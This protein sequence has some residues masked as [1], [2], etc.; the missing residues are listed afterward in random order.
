[1]MSIGYAGGLFL[2]LLVF[3]LLLII[4]TYI[5][6]LENMGC[7]CSNHPNKEFIKSYTIISIVFLLFTSFISMK[8]VYDNFGEI[9]AIM[10]S[11][12]TLVFYIIFVFYIYMSFEYVRYLINEKCK[13]SDDWRREVI[14]IGTMIEFILFS[15]ALLTGIIIPVLTESM[16]SIMSKAQ[17][18]RNDVRESI[19]NPIGSIQKL[20]SKLKK[21]VKGVSSFLKKSSK[22]LKK[23]SRS[24]I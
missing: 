18:F 22:D 10:L 5:V 2:N 23:L 20:P 24:K 1:M 4:Y 9:V 16:L 8:D 21:G 15:V 11:L 12:A 7:A 6:K 14:M 17:T 13:C 3:I 19:Y